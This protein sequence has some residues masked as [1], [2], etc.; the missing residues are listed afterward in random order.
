MNTNTWGKES[1]IL[2]VMNICRDNKMQVTL[3]KMKVLDIMPLKAG[4][5]GIEVFG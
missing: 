3:K 5:L 1:V 2:N 4:K